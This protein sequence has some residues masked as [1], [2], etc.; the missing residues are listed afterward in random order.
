MKQNV[1]DRIYIIIDSTSFLSSSRLDY[2][3]T[4]PVYYSRLRATR[5]I[6][7]IICYL[8]E[9]ENSRMGCLD[10]LKKN[11]H[12]TRIESNRIL[13]QRIINLVKKLLEI[14]QMILYIIF[15]LF[16]LTHVFRMR[17]HSIGYNVNK[18]DLMI[19]N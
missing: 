11:P 4:G 15:S 6:I 5:V 18:F 17:T 14:A 2:K 12:D 8:L 7:V 9:N 1:A 16:K 19:L 13:R 3:Y 10:G